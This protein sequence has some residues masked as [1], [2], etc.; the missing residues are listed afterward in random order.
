MGTKTFPKDDLLDMVWGSVAFD[1][2]WVVEDTHTHSSR[3]KEHRTM[4]FTFDGKFYRVNY[5]KGATEHQG[6]EPFEDMGKDIPCVE[7][8]PVEVT[9][10]KYVNVE[11]Q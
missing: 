5:M 3:W 9:V 4:V 6:T 2:Y 1:G 10:T 11:D 7:V 8:V